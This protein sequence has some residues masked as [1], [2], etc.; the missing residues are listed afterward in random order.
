MSEP[1]RHTPHRAPSIS[2][3]PSQRYHPYSSGTTSLGYQGLEQPQP[4]YLTGAAPPELSSGPARGWLGHNGAISFPA[5]NA[6]P[7]SS[8]SNVPPMFVDTIA[9]EQHLL[10]MSEIWK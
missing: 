9:T 6:T 5:G 8:G 2:R 10:G 7:S 3:Q 4:G 1:P